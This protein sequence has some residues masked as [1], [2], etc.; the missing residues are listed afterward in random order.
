MAYR[1][2]SYGR[3]RSSYSRP[4]SVRRNRYGSRRVARRATA[5]TVRIVLEQPGGGMGVVSRPGVP[6]LP[7]AAQLP[8][9]RAA[10]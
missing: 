3:R 7:G 8:L 2:R 4:R 1:R 9:R 6:G 10:F 5:S